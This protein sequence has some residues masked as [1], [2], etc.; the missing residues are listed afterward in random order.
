MTQERRRWGQ[1]RLVIP[2]N[3]LGRLTQMDEPGLKEFQKNTSST[4]NQSKTKKARASFPFLAIQGQNDLKL[5]M[6]LNVIEPDIK[7]ILIIGDRGT[8]KS[9]TIQH[10]LIYCLILLLLKV[11]LTIEHP[12]Q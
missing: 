4:S 8:G 7:G 11:T 5:G 3:Q 12:F 2:P 9:T 10:L 1:S 6:I